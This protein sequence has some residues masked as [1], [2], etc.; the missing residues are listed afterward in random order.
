MVEEY[1]GEKGIFGKVD[2]TF[3]I[4]E[5]E[6][7]PAAI[8]QLLNNQMAGLLE[9]KSVLDQIDAEIKQTT[10]ANENR[11]AKNKN[12]KSREDDQ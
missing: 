6:Q 5:G 8:D 10:E 7:S 4:R 3:V 11:T 9:D 2:S 12:L 1:A